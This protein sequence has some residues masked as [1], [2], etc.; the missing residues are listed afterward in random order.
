[1]PDAGRGQEEE[2]AQVEEDQ[3]VV[4]ACDIKDVS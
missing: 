4:V 2:D 1:M 3:G